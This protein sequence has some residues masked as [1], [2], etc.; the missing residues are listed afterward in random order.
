MLLNSQHGKKLMLLMKFSALS[1][2]AIALDEIRTN[3]SD[4]S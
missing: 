3:S 2:I 4:A 1:K